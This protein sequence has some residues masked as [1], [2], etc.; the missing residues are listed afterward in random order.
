MT[1]PLVQILIFLIITFCDIGTSIYNRYYLDVDN[2]VAYIAHFAGAVA[3]LLV[4]VQTLKNIRPTTKEAILWWLC[5][6]IYIIVTI[7]CIILNVT[8]T[9]I[10]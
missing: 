3:G 7:I 2:Q 4:G 5:L 1:I 9:T 8:G 6:V 10:S